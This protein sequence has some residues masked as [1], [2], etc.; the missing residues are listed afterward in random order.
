[1]DINLLKTIEERVQAALEHSKFYQELYKNK[2]LSP[3]TE[4]VFKSLPIVTKQEYLERCDRKDLNNLQDECNLACFTGGSTAVQKITF[5]NLSYSKR[6]IFIL[7]QAMKKLGIQPGDIVLNLFAPGMWGA[8]E[9]FNRGLEET[10]C[11]II[12]LG[13][14]H[15]MEEIVKFILEFHPTV[16]IGMPHILVALIEHLLSTE[17]TEQA[18]KNINKVLYAGQGITKEQYSFIKQYIPQISSPIYSAT[19]SGVVGYQC[20]HCPPGFFHK[21]PDVYIELF[22][23]E[24]NTPQEKKGEVVITSLANRV[25]PCIRYRLSDFIEW[26]DKPCACG[27]P[28]QLFHI[29]GRVGDL[30]V[31]KCPYSDI[32][33]PLTQYLGNRISQNLQ[34]YIDEVNMNN[35]PHNRLTFRYQPFPGTTEK[36][37]KQLHDD[38]QNFLQTK[39]PIISNWIQRNIE[40]V[41]IQEIDDYTMLKNPKTGKIRLVV[42]TRKYI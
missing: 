8:F 28:A 21:S 27:D 35:A 42:D 5:W 33:T 17:E 39:H 6:Q 9:G 19:E 36:E 10:G 2:Q 34:L 12:P 22:K 25:A 18:L 30:C 29:S 4:E 32:V 26:Q 1:M 23:P 41:E 31:L 13:H 3:F 38:F 37:K 11:T 24:S 16:I 15:S 14:H 20:K 7:S 40:Y